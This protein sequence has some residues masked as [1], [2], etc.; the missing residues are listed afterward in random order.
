[1]GIKLKTESIKRDVY[2]FVIKSMLHDTLHTSKELWLSKQ[3]ALDE[4]AEFQ[5]VYFKGMTGNYFLTK[6]FVVVI[7]PKK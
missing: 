7:N 2:A 3:E 6:H 1:M 5:K 4:A